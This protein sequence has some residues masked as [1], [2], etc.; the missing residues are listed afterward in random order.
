MTIKDVFINDAKEPSVP[1]DFHQLIGSRGNVL[2][3][4]KFIKRLTLTLIGPSCPSEQI[5]RTIVIST[6]NINCKEPQ[7]LVM[8][9]ISM[10]GNEITTFRQ[11]P[12]R[13]IK[14]KVMSK[15]I[16]SYICPPQICDEHSGD[17][18]V[19]WN[20]VPWIPQPEK[21]HLLRVNV[22]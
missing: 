9:E 5:Q 3:Q 17:I 20:Y 13:R 1:D 15:K 16:C 22:L 10:F 11:C 6:K 7:L 14:K 2:I 18:Y 21:L 19:Q 4:P 8:T 12:I